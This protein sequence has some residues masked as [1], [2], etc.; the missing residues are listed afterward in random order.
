MDWQ[1]LR[2]CENENEY[3]VVAT[4]RVLLESHVDNMDVHIVLAA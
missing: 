2:R 1:V 3:V 4:Q